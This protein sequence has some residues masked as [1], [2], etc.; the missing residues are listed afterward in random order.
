M[1]FS[2]SA[3]DSPRLLAAFEIR[4]A[5]TLPNILIG[6]GA[7]FRS[8]LIPP[9]TLSL[10]CCRANSA[11]SSSFDCLM[12]P[13][14]WAAFFR[15]FSFFLEDEYKRTCCLGITTAGESTLGCNRGGGETKA[16]TRDVVVESAATAVRQRA[17]RRS[18]LASLTDA[19]LLVE[20][21]AMLNIVS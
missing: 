1:V 6:K 12:M 8:S 20:R 14:F 2:C 9:E 3:M 4:G 5:K 10:T 13:N 15:K 16:P 17:C 18:L 21:R 11:F 19:V 7:S